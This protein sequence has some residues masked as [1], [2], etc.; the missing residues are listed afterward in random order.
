[1]IFFFDRSVEL[2]LASLSKSLE[3]SMEL[4][5]ILGYLSFF[6]GAPL[7]LLFLFVRI[8]C[9]LQ[10]VLSLKPSKPFEV[11]GGTVPP[12]WDHAAQS[13]TSPKSSEGVY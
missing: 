12:L 5:F 8:M 6:G 10:P 2:F 13:A 11:G 4:P 9:Y 1:M 7:P 3:L